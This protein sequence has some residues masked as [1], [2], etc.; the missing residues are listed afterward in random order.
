MG[1]TG[2]SWALTQ[3]FKSMPTFRNM[4]TRLGLFASLLLAAGCVSHGG[5]TA[6]FGAPKAYSQPYY[7]WGRP[8]VQ[9]YYGDRRPHY[10]DYR[11]GHGHDHR[12]G[13]HHPPRP[14]YR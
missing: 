1:V 6:Y 5:G 4:L 12:H 8:Y 3:S 7:G 11:R 14:R 13:D 10:K 2:P 9:P